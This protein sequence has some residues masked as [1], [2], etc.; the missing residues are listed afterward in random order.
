MN[1][2][3]VSIVVPTFNAASYL[4]KCVE[5][6]L[7]LE[8]PIYE[9]IVVD[10]GSSDGTAEYLRG[11]VD[12]RV[13][14]LT[15]HKNL[16]TCLARNWGIAQA[17]YPI[18]A[19]TD[20][21]CVVNPRWL[22]EIVQ[23]FDGDRVGFISGEVFYVRPGYVGYF[24]ERLVRNP[25]GNWPMGCN[26][27]FLKR[28]LDE[29]GGFD[30]EMFLY[31]NEDTEIALRLLV[32]NWEWRTCPAAVVY[33]QQIEWTVKSLL[34]TARYASVWPIL[35][36]RYPRH[37]LYFKPFIRWGWLAY[38][39]TLMQLVLSPIL[40]WPALVAYLAR[41]HRDLKLFFA[42]WPVYLWLKRWYLWREAI[43]HRVFMI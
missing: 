4:K 37:Y 15:N 2:P 12:P 32:N 26:L 43:R 9:V 10:D 40:V 42:W 19:F 31:G 3:G 5:S 11:V 33:H 18:V 27:A 36:T 29:I 23:G 13:K 7:A 30:P 22:T 41:G 14:V 28:A 35:K 24:P 39:K 16:G 8:Y 38:P 20:H 6:L 25:V 34:R 17:R 21:D 1:Q